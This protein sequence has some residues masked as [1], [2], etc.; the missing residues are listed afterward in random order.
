MKRRDDAGAPFE[1]HPADRRLLQG[2]V[3]RKLAQSQR[4]ARSFTAILSQLRPRFAWGVALL[5]VLGV[6]AWLL[7]PV[8]GN[9]HPAA[10]L[11]KNEPE[12]GAVPAKEP[13]PPEP[14]APA[15]VASSPAGAM[16]GKPAEVASPYTASPA[17]ATPTRQLSVPPP[18]LAEDSSAAMSTREAGEKLAQAAAPQLAA[19]QAQARFE[20]NATG[21]T[22]PKILAGAVNGPP[23]SLYGLADKVPPG[24]TALAVPA[25]PPAVALTPGPAG[26]APV[27]ERAKVASDQ[28]EVPATD[29]GPL[30]RARRPT[31]SVNLP[32]PRTACP[33]TSP[34]P[35]GRLRGV[36]FP[37]SSF[38][39]RREQRPREPGQQSHRRISCAGLVSSATGRARTADC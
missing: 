39:W 31:V 14:T 19:G 30:S 22:R 15:I 27:Y 10:N 32:L 4:G 35:S 3:S 2:E 11:A 16:V 21:S 5:A 36:L 9:D 29:I 13:L 23:E 18:A 37:N 26:A 20:I 17:L 28:S 8:P 34:R 12:S 38:K 7:L 25:A 33:K 24:A 6:A 1:L